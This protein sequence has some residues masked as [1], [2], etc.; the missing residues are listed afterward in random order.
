MILAP[1]SCQ[2]NQITQTLL[3]LYK[4]ENLPFGKKQEKAIIILLT[5]FR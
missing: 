1:T 2:C 3:A 4:V 5:V